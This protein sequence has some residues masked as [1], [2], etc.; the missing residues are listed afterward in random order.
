[1][2]DRYEYKGID[3]EDF[4]SLA[5]EFL[6]KKQPDPELE[7]FFDQWVYSTGV[8]ELTMTHAFKNLRVTG[9]VRQSGVGED[10]SI[11]V[12]LH[13][14]LPGNKTITHWIRTSSEPVQ[15]SIPVSVAPLKVELGSVLQY[16]N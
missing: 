15:F 1:M 9:A 10:F 14:R 11:D 16:R 4:R 3:T 6:P 7:G 5:V 2:R 13:V 8:P 12:P